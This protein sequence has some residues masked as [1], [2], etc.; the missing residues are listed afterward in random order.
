MS[1]IISI[2]KGLGTLKKLKKKA[3][4]KGKTIINFKIVIR[5]T[6]ITFCISSFLIISLLGVAIYSVTGAVTEFFNKVTELFGLGNT[7][8]EDMIDEIESHEDELNKILEETGAKI[9]VKKINKYIKML[10]ENCKGSIDRTI[11]KYESDKE[12]GLDSAKNLVNKEDIKLDVYDYAFDYGVQWQFLTAT[13]LAIFSAA[14][15]NNNNVVE[16]NAH[17]LY[18]K[19]TWAEDYTKDTYNYE[20]TWVERFEIDEKTG[21]RTELP[22]KKGEHSEDNKE[23]KYT[24]KKYPLAIPKKIE[25]MFGTYTFKV[26]K[27]VVTKDEEWSNAYIVEDERESREVLDYIKQ[28]DA[29]YETKE[30]IKML[31]ERDHSIYY[32]QV[33]PENNK[34]NAKFLGNTSKTYTYRGETDKEY[35]YSYTNNISVD[36]SDYNIYI[37]KDMISE[38]R[39]YETFKYIGKENREYF[40]GNYEQI[41]VMKT[42]TTYKKV[43]KRT[44]KKIVEDQL[45]GKSLSFDPSNFIKFLNACDMSVN[46]DLELVIEC[47]KSLPS[48]SEL[49]NELQKIVDGNYGDISLGTGSGNI[50]GNFSWTGELPMFYQYLEPWANH[51]F[52]GTTINVAGCGPTTMSMVVSGLSSKIPEKIDKNKD[53]VATPIEMA[54]WTMANNLSVIG[55][56]SK[57]ELIKK[58]S[59]KAGLVCSDEYYDGNRA[60]N[61][62]KDGKVVVI[63]IHAGI[64][65]PKTQGHFMVLTGLDENGNIKINDPGSESVT[66]K[67]WPLGVIKNDT[68]KYWTIY[69]PNPTISDNI[70]IK[71]SKTQ[72]VKFRITY[73]TNYD[74]LMEGGQFDCMGIPLVKHGEPVVAAPMN[75]PYGSY[76]KLDK[77]LQISAGSF[78][79]T[80]IVRTTSTFKVVDRGGMINW[81]NANTCHIDVFIP[82]VNP[83]WIVKNLSNT[84]ITGT[85]YYK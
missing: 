66:S 53:G 6:L 58:A 28:G 18:S 61:D 13:D 52:N 38:S 11:Y 3:K 62:L 9:S 1:F 35:I 70:P 26:N 29:I 43:Y 50:D 64:T 49:M 33:K 72:K 27:D 45:I 21:Y 76:I 44:R 65:H 42:I 51:P 83:Q 57:H 69:N 73:Y 23:K 31:N 78:V 81:D 59:E 46:E 47:L 12:S 4:M 85:I 24:L 36:G 19:F 20:E 75:I 82:N 48:G 60:Y 67:T 32:V 55:S 37:P 84:E 8:F 41:K 39:K 74:D 2:L 34:S 68:T 16:N 71:P 63:L 56:G 77:P 54:D 30:V 79:P 17:L 40:T 7:P 15:N 5:D 25:T 80:R 10:E 22:L 14:D